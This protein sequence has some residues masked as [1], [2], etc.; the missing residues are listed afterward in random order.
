MRNLIWFNM[1]SVDGR[2]EGPDHNLDWHNTDDEFNQF[3]VEQL[4]SAGLLLFGRVTYEMMADFWP[5][6]VE[7]DPQVADR[8]NTLPKIVFSRLL[9]RVEWNNTRLIKSDPVAEVEQLKQQP[10]KDMFLF[11]SANLAKT[12]VNSGCIDEYRLMVNP[13]ILGQGTLNFQDVQSPVPLE[14]IST[15]A[16]SN[17]NVLLSYRLSR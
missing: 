14:L 7:D 8:M 10:G 3:A 2:F 17:G 16:F 5:T 9:K 12:L 15:R 13:I 1:V 11:G 6:H 4:D